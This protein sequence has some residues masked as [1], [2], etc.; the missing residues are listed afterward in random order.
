MLGFHPHTNIEHDSK[1]DLGLTLTKLKMDQVDQCIF[2]RLTEQVLG[3]S[4]GWLG[5]RTIFVFV[6]VHQSDLEHVVR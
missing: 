4:V 1:T 2:F 3:A 6:A 5:M